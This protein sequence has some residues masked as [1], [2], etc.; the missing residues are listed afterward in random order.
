MNERVDIAVGRHTN[1]TGLPEADDIPHRVIIRGAGGETHFLGSLEDLELLFTNG[2][3]S[4]E[5]LRNPA[6]SPQ[7][8][9]A[10]PPVFMESGPVR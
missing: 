3:R 5:R 4:V 2:L 6:P 1:V 10:R 8:E 9:R 7:F